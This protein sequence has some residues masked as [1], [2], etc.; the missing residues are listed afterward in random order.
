MPHFTTIQ[1]S[2]QRYT[3]VY[4]NITNLSECPKWL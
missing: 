4:F 2:R 3:T 1:N